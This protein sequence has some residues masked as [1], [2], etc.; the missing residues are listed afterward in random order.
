MPIMDVK[1]LLKSVSHISLGVVLDDGRPW[2]IVVSVQKYDK[3]VVEWFSKTSAVHSK[4]IHERPDVA[5]S[6]FTTKRS[7]LGEIGWYAHATARKV[8][9][10]PGGISRYRAVISDAWYTD[11]SKKKTKLRKSEF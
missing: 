6:A 8:Y 2:V 3:G 5:L 9:T 11:K 1:E 10:L 7:K 4:A